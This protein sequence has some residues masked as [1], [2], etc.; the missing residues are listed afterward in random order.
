MTGVGGVPQL[1]FPNLLKRMQM[2]LYI[3]ERG[4]LHAE[5]LAKTGWGETGRPG[6]GSGVEQVGLKMYLCSTSNVTLI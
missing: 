6:P 4:T 2:L 3:A 1:T 5:I